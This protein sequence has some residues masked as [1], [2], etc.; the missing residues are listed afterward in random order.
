MM[1][2][3]GLFIPSHYCFVMIRLNDIDDTSTYHGYELQYGNNM[4]DNINFIFFG[5]V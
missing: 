5:I 3:T 1:F 2:S 4:C